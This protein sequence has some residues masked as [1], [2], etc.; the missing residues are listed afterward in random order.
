MNV[1]DSV[2]M[3]RALELAEAA[4][5]RGEVPVGAV[6]VKD[7]KI[8]AEA[9]NRVEELKNPFAHAEMLAMNSALEKLGGWRLPDCTLYVTLEPC[10]MCAGAI[11]H[12]RIKRV[13]AAA[14]DP[15]AGACGSVT[16]ITGE[17]RLN[18]QPEV[19]FGLMR[20]E[21]SDMLKR[22]FKKRREEKKYKKQED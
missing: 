22:F 14:Y 18:H 12:A 6:V 1:S 4:A 11:V 10:A 7:G 21:S 3:T 8:I 5:L 20:E 19:E 13:V 9:S 17:K 2:F 15:K 16:D